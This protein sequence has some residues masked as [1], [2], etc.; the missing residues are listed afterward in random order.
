MQ[1]GFNNFDNTD[2]EIVRQIGVGSFSKVFL[3]K[4]TN[5]L[6]HVDESDLFIEKRIDVNELVKTYISTNSN[7]NSQQKKTSIKTRT[8]PTKRAH[9]MSLTPYKSTVVKLEET[10]Y[11]YQRLNELIQSEIEVLSDID[12]N[13]IIRF[14]G[15]K[16]RRGVYYLRME[17]CNAGDTFEYLKSG[18]GPRN[19]HNGMGPE[20]VNQ[21]IQQTAGALEYLHSKSIIHRD[22]K[23]QNILIDVN[24]V[25]SVSS[26]PKHFTFKLS[27]FGFAC[28]DQSHANQDEVL[29]KKY[30]K[31]CGTPYYMAPEIVTNINLLENITVYKPR[32]YNS[33]FYDC[34][35]DVWSYGICLYELVCNALPFV[36]VKTLRDLYDIYVDTE[37]NVQTVLY[38]KILS[39]YAY[40][41]PL[42]KC[43]LVKDYQSRC[44]SKTIV[45]L[46]HRDILKQ[47]NAPIDSVVDLVHCDLDYTG[48]SRALQLNIV[49]KPVLVDCIDSDW[50]RVSVTD[51]FVTGTSVASET[52][53]STQGIF[54][55]VLGS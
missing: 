35:V 46:F 27:D 44:T 51:T 39:V 24:D 47:Q 36:H 10:E 1:N 37:V 33:V 52:K 43:M 13:N 7:A 40:L 21:F 9:K 22:I 50:Q 53:G 20:F 8:I 19:A 38:E 45:E 49:R 28:Y 12:H 11:Y 55:W 3:C 17:Y 29:S 54:K 34:R 2:C 25:S 4:A 32:T 14:F 26:H 15:S 6:L 18:V 31:L 5:G 16:T 48:T 30:F 23:L 41:Q 42:L